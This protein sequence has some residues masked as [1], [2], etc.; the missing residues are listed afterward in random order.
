[1]KIG[2]FRGKVESYVAKSVHD[3]PENE[4]AQEEESPGLE[5]PHQLNNLE[6]GENESPLD[7]VPSA[8]GFDDYGEG[9]GEYGEEDNIEF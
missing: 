6:G 9:E 7:G 8:E 1:M 5:N 3:V 4:N 2:N